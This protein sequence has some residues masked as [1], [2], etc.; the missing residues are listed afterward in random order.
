MQ[1]GR[2]NGSLHGNSCRL[3][4]IWSTSWAWTSTARALGADSSMP[5]SSTLKTVRTKW[6]R[7]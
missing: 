6:P 7:S 5:R 2:P 4:L 1:V 3:S